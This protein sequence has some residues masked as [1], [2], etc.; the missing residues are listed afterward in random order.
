MKSEIPQAAITILETLERNGHEAYLVGGCV[1]D[2]LLGRAPLDYDIATQATPDQIEELFACHRLVTT[3]R[4]HG[5]VGVISDGA[6]YEVTTYRVDGTY[7]DCRRPDE[8]RFSR[9]L[10][11]DAKRRDFTVNAMA[12]NKRGEIV[13]PVGG[14]KDLAEKT[15][16]AV[17]DPVRRF[18]ED[19]LRIMRAVRF[20]A[21][22]GFRVEEK[23]ERAIREKRRSLR[24]IAPERLQAELNKLLRSD[25]AQAAA[26]LRRFREVVAVFL[27]ELIPTFDF[28][29]KNPYHCYDVWEHTLHALAETPADLTL[30]LSALF[31]DTGKP[32]CFTEE[33]GRGHFYGHEGVSAELAG[34]ALKRLRYDRRTTEAV[35]E[36]IS[37]HGTVLHG[38][39]KYAK[40]KLNRL[41]GERLLQLIALERADV[42]AQ[43]EHVRA[44]R[45]ENLDAFRVLVKRLLEEKA[46][47]SRGD[48]A[49]RGSDLLA[50]GIA[51]GPA[52]GRVLGELLEQV[53]GGT[54][55]NDRAL[56]LAEAERM[57]KHRQS[58]LR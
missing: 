31:H 37:L 43:A 5:T 7:S 36:L 55:E 4:K 38:T 27:P 44:E 12:M 42:S 47:F 22:L 56:L 48:L 34:A 52:V 26:A 15:L 1:R 8:V 28:A 10:E 57:W 21:Q 29:Q 2:L 20:S 13:D 46:C 49:V 6:M 58:E 39:E 11:E 24:A 50:L 53:I 30:R 25:G 9:S 23:T 14:R 45:I 16:R 32:V 54:L 40:R 18:E 19:A 51:N 41:G 35:I 3:G 33:N 17:G